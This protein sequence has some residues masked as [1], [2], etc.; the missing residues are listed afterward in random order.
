MWLSSF[1]SVPGVSFC[2]HEA[3]EFASSAEEF[4]DNAETYC[5]GIDIYGN[6]DSANLYG[7]RSMLALRPMTKVVWINRPM[8][9]V[10][11][12]MANIGM[13]MNDSTV[14]HIT[15]LR[16]LCWEYFDLRIDFD[17]LV[18]ACECRRIWEFCLPDV[19]FDYGRWGAYTHKK[20]CYSKEN[21]MPNKSF[22]KFLNWAKRE[23]DELRLEGHTI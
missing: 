5:H 23:V 8:C 19:P 4:W 17:G 13:P 14:W 2:T 16:D 7:L 1:L 18:H 11:E 10:R 21:P 12:S 6:S 20:I 9:E 3:T 22:S 15:K